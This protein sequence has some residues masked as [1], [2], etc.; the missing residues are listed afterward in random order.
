[1]KFGEW[2]GARDQDSAPIMKEILPR[3]LAPPWSACGAWRPRGTLATAGENA[4]FTPSVMD[5][6]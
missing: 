2:R 3:K 6:S 1:M 5:T 4:I